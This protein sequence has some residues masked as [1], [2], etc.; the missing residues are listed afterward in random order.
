MFV[1][2]DMWS[3][4]PLLHVYDDKMD[5]HTPVVIFLH[6]FQSAKEHN[7]HYAYQFVKKGIRV[8]MPDAKF[9]G[10]RTENLPEEKMNL[11]FWGIVINSI[12]EVGKIYDELKIRGLTASGKIGVAGS[13]MGGIVTSG[14]LKQYDWIT[15]A[16]ICM[17][18][19][20]FVDLA[21]YQLQ[22]FAALGIDVPM[23]EEQK[24]QTQ[25]LLADYDITKTPEKF[26][27]RPVLFWHGE[28]DQTVP[29]KNTYHFYMQL[30]SYYRQNPDYLKF[31]SSKN[32]G[33]KVPRA[34]VL[35]VTDWLS[36]YLA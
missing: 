7:L 22:Q 27:Q 1:Q 11:H 35:A 33:H 10:D 17:G 6:G 32:D 4:I 21:N 8:I 30:R 13:S 18:A 34:G 20:G 25:T 36:Q 14:C 28:K 12:E 23:T 2:N 9:H 24:L 5:E 26:Q 16:A 15:G 3:E 19:P 29:F 31:I